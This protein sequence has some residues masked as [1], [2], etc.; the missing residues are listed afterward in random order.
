MITQST[1]DEV[2]K[3]LQLHENSRRIKKLIFSACKNTWENDQHILDKFELTQLIQELYTLCPTKE[4]LNSNL[5]QIVKTLNKPSEYSIVADIILK[6]LEKIYIIPEETTGII[7]NQNPKEETTGIIY[8]QTQQTI[9][10]N[11]IEDLTN[12]QIR[13]EYNPFDLRQNIMKFT[14]PL[15]AKLV[16]FFALENKTYFQE[17]DWL[18]LREEQLDSFLERLWYFCPTFTELESK[19]N[20]AVTSLGNEDES[21]QAAGAIMQAMRG[22]YRDIESHTNQYQLSENYSFPKTQS[23]IEPNYASTLINPNDID[24]DEDEDDQNNTCQLISP[25]TISMQKKQQ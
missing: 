20:H 17:E 14:N 8:N 4:H 22:L 7:Y 23:L 10:S 24:E 12:Q 25:P 1:V 6:E 15:R 2:A 11:T 21:Y 16:L 3:S 18:K 13:Y 5:N 9:S 19:L